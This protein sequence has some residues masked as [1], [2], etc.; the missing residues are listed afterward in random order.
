MEYQF[1]ELINRLLIHLLFVVGED[2]GELQHLG[3]PRH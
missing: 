2:Q 1:R 3:E